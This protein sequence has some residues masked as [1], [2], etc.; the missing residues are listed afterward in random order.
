MTGSSRK[1]LRTS[2]TQEKQQWQTLL[3]YD[4]SDANQNYM[5]KT[6]HSAHGSTMPQKVVRIFTGRSLLSPLFADSDIKIFRFS[7]RH[8]RPVSALRCPHRLR[9]SSTPDA[10][11]NSNTC[12]IYACKSKRDFYSLHYIRQITHF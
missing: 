9:P 11:R 6:Q 12:S 1:I 2:A 8:P 5:L 3:M 4:Y 10:I 7:S